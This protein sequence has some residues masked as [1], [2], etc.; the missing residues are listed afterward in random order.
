M[1]IYVISYRLDSSFADR[2]GCAII[3]K[4]ERKM[5]NKITFD[6]GKT[7]FAN[8]IIL[9]NKVALSGNAKI[10]LFSNNHVLTETDV[11]GTFTQA[12][13]GGYADQV[14][15]GWTDG[16]IDA[17]D[18]DTWTGST[19][20]F[21]ATSATNLPQTLYG[22]ICIDNGA[23]VALFGQNFAPSVTL[24]NS[25]DGFTLTPTFSVG[26]IF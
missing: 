11:I 14:S 7:Y 15:S 22:Y 19:L 20:T 3:T 16:G 25:G 24:S 4:R 2:P 1:Q 12:T 9:A 18:R 8:Q 23:T 13:Y 10:R 17:N 26:S 21:S 6:A 5:A